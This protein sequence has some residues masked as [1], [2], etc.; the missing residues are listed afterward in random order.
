MT[1]RRVL[2]ALLLVLGTASLASAQ[3][4]SRKK[5]IA[6][7]RLSYYQWDIPESVLGGIDEELKGV[8]VNI[9][10]FNVLG[11]TQRL[12]PGDLNEFIDKIQRYKQDRTEIPQEVQMGREFFTEADFE[13]LV[14]SFVVVVP[15]V[16]SYL[17][18]VKP[19]GEFH[20]SVKTSF[21]FV[22]VEQGTTFAQAF[23]ETEGT[24]KSPEGAARGALDG[25]AMQLT[26][27]VRKIPEFQLRT[28]VLEVRGR[29][30][31]L[32]LGR[33]MGIQVGDEYALV[34]S[35]VLD[36]GKTLTTE[37]GL[38]VIKEVSDEVSVGQVLYAR[39]RPREGD[40]LREV[41]LLGVETTPYLHVAAGLLTN[42]GITGLAGIRGSVSRG[43]YGV[44]P[45]FGLE[46]P[47]IAN[48]A[49]ALPL[50][51]YGGVEYVTYLG[52]LS[53]TPMAA[54]GLGGAYLWY[55]GESVSED[56]KFWLTHGGGQVNLTLS[57]L[58]SKKTK[59]T[60]DLGYL[61]WFSFIPT[62]VFANDLF[63]PSYD[64]VFAG[65]GLTIK[66]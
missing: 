56:Q 40:Q 19:S 59:L 42:R 60:V 24:A 28:G 18:E 35:R 2:S 21:S 47:F 57:Y 7:F 62:K 26:Y 65:A 38:L 30:V 1:S 22:N 25:I 36:S 55:L 10:R 37:N 53:V 11:M 46:M 12:E 4:V 39:P 48:I 52:R 14:G 41:P 15:S 5:D 32:E 33:D 66:L 51:L 27:E 6:V 61:L 63:F 45:I 8:F 31:I 23:V 54:L 49:A 20:V 13:R 29:Q 44:R 58:F 16:A 3:E 34:A 43:F 9:G 50:N 64:G 17:L